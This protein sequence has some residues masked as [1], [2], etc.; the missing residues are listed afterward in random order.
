MDLEGLGPGERAARYR[1]MARAQMERAG[2]SG[3]PEMQAVCLELAAMWTR[4][5][6]A[7]ERQGAR[8]DGA[9]LRSED[10]R[11]EA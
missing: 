11:A 10:D 2:Q 8:G 3:Q 1:E 9:K 5:A 6:E 7:A 4:L